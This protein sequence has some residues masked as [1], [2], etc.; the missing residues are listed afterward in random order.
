MKLALAPISYYWPRETVL[1]FYRAAAHTAVDVVYLGE[2][3]CSRRHELKLQDWL[4]VAELLTAAGKEVLLSTPA[5]I[6]SESDLKALR[7]IVE[8]GRFMV[9]ANDM[10]AVRLLEGRA[11]FAAGSGLNVYNPDVL[12]FLAGLGARRWVAPV[13]LPSAALAAMQAQRPAGVQTEVFAYGRLPLALSAR[14]FTAR[15]FNLQ[16]DDCGFRCL[17]YSDGLPLNTRDG[18][19][20]LVLNGLQTQSAAVFNLIRE[21]PDMARLGVDVIRL[22]PRS[23][24]MAQIAELFRRVAQHPC[25]AAAAAAQLVAVAPGDTCDGY[26]HGAPG[27]E[28]IGAAGLP[29]L[30]QA[31]P[32]VSPA[33]ESRR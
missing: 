25:E 17:D 23:Q 26:W 31:P 7:R 5:L 16:K 20:F 29:D 19:A 27:I 13:E 2:T 22:S 8:N 18:R 28:S 24:G 12:A 30:R 33:T 3:V 14:C 1:G 15:R 6:E 21:V 9:E 4:E 11:P 10:G 32:A